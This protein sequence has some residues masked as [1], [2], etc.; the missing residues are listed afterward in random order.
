MSVP[1]YIPPRSRLIPIEVTFQAT[2]NATTPFQ[3]DF[4]IAANKNKFIMKLFRQKVYLLERFSFS[5]N[6]PE[7]DYQTAIG[8]FPNPML[9]LNMQKQNQ[10]PVY[11]KPFPLGRYYE[12]NEHIVCFR[13]QL[14]DNLQGTFKARL[15]QP[16]ALIPVPTVI[17]TWAA[18]I[19]EIK[20]H[21]WIA[22]YLAP[23]LKTIGPFG[24]GKEVKK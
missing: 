6:I 19:Y 2:Y 4:N 20:E 24:G 10:S 14:N 21:N 8:T 1:L 3:Y 9:F 22:N 12:N 7:A 17:V 15:D 5:A 23:Y 13:S 18:Q 16:A 11:Q